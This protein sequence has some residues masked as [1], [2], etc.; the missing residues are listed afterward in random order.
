MYSI[1]TSLNKSIYESKHQVLINSVKKIC[2]NVDFYVYNENSYLNESL[3]IDGAINLDLFKEI[4]DLKSFLENSKFK[5]CHLIGKKNKEEYLNY[6]DR[7]LSVPDY[8][9]RNSIFWFRKICAYYH[10]SKICKSPILIWLDADM[11]LKKAIDENFLN[12][13]KKYDVATI[14]RKNFKGWMFTDSGLIAFNLNHRGRFFID[15]IFNF[16]K[17][18]QVFSEYRWDDSYCID[19]VIQKCREW[20]KACGLNKIF[21]CDFDY[22]EYFFHNKGYRNG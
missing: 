4:K 9:N 14:Y 12:F 15:S 22:E 1:V 2:P 8:W 11:L 13:I 10:C 19:I 6:P 7:Y 3:D 17:S 16:Y 20:L 18:G 21:G 5:D